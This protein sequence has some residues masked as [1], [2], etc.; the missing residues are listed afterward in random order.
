MKLKKVGNFKEK[1]EQQTIKGVTV[2][3]DNGYRKGTDDMYHC[4]R[5]CHWR[6]S[7]R[8]PLP[9]DSV[10][11]YNVYH[12]DED[13]TLSDRIREVLEPLYMSFLDGMEK[14]AQMILKPKGQVKSFFY[15]NREGDDS[16]L[17]LWIEKIDE[18]V[19]KLYQNDFEEFVKDDYEGCEVDINTHYC[20]LWE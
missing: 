19:S 7:P 8:C 4:C 14:D 18:A 17:D 15:V 3:G 5:W 16:R 13:G 2:S 20:S 1:Y 12:V 10:D 6:E 11:D 9:K